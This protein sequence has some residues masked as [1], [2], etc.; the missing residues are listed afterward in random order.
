[1]PIARCLLADRMATVEP[2]TKVESGIPVAA[3]AKRKS[4]FTVARKTPNELLI[5]D[6]KNWRISCGVFKVQ[7]EYEVIVEKAKENKRTIDAEM[8]AQGYKDYNAFAR[9]CD[10]F[11]LTCSASELAELGSG[12]VLYFHFLSFIMI[13]L[14]CFIVVSIPALTYYKDQNNIDEWFWHEWSSGWS[15]TDTSCECLGSNDGVTGPSDQFS[16]SDY[17][18]SCMAWDINWCLAADSPY[19][20]PGQWCCRSWCFAK[21][22][23]VAPNGDSPSMWHRHYRG[24]VRATSTCAQNATLL[25]QCAH[26][27]DTAMN[28]EGV[29]WVPP[30]L[31]IN[32]A[33][34]TPGNLGPNGGDEASI[35]VAC[36]SI[37]PLMG[38]LAVAAYQHQLRT[39]ERID[40]DNTSPHD[41]AIMVKGLPPTVTDEKAILG[42]FR[43][44]AIKGQDDVEVVKVVI[45]W[46]AADFM[47]RIQEMTNLKKQLRRLAPDRADEEESIKKRIH[48]ITV[49]LATTATQQA[50]KLRSSGVAVVV[51]RYQQDMRACLSRW[52]G[53]W[54]SYWYCE[55]R[56]I[57]WLPKN[58]GLLRGDAL[59]QF[60]VGDGT[61][62]SLQVIRAPNPGD[63]NWMKLGVNKRQRQLRLARTHGL[64]LLVILG[65]FWATWGLNLL[66]ELAKDESAK[67]TG[68]VYWGVRALSL[69]PGLGIGIVNIVLQFLARYLGEGEY[70]DTHT[71]KEFSQAMKMSVGMMI[72]T[73]GVLLWANAKPREWYEKGGLVDDITWVLVMDAVV[74]QLWMFMDIVYLMNSYQ[75]RKVSPERLADWNDKIAKNNPPKTPEQ[76]TEL[77]LVREQ[78]LHA[79]R[80]FEPDSPDNPQR[81]AAAINS[82]VCCLFYMPLIPLLPFICLGGLL[83]QYWVDKFLLL[84]WQKRPRHQN[85]HMAIWSL[86]FL[87]VCAPSLWAAS[88]F[89][90]LTPS[91]NDKNANWTVLVLSMI[92]ALTASLV[93]MKFWRAILCL[94]CIQMEGDKSILED[95]SLEDYYNAQHMWSKEMKYHKDQFLYKMLKEEKNPEMLKP[96]EDATIRVEDVKGYYGAAV[97]HV[98]ETAGQ[99]PAAPVNFGGAYGY[100]MGGQDWSGW[101]GQGW[102]GYSDWSADSAGGYASP[103][104]TYGG[105]GHAAGGQAYG[106]QAYGGAAVAPAAGYGYGASGYTTSTT[107]VALDTSAPAYRLEGTVPGSTTTATYAPVGTMYGAAQYVTPATGFHSPTPAYEWPAH[108]Y[109]GKATPGYGR[110]RS[111]WEYERGKHG[112]YVPFDMA[113]QMEVEALYQGY[114]AGGGRN[115][116]NIRSRGIN[117]SVDFATMTQKTARARPHNIRRRESE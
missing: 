25:A 93:P 5:D 112:E 70:H 39:E 109:T 95:E 65:S 40:A 61:A 98:A 110:L 51:F 59:P 28:E 32:E 13:L 80:A 107:A 77:K 26:L 22:T 101:G 105:G 90:F 67:Q 2:G 44:H 73:S 52:R 81:Y 106:G 55:A 37:T 74:G 10:R 47:G 89:L 36:I 17:G 71:E 27:E 103:P 4:R 50:A 18:T 20:Q 85:S 46:D 116:V 48:K 87:K 16:Q 3:V 9:S 62:V 64:M 53:F 60:P 82:F 68:D 23:C 30:D 11:A 6:F 66:Q 15:S 83:L 111:W 49:E 1:M 57:T 97:Q 104:V 54:P 12:F 86:K 79:K 38:L 34:L 94:P 56:D 72:N 33:Y 102:S 24:L 99:A 78:V 76:Q 41:F 114:K 115:R 92:M 21:S 84:R 88:V 8:K 58:N 31:F 100:A 117:V 42:F 91:W 7:K 69:L 43:E 96:G 113:C 63:I 14:L 75:R 29:E 19:S 45:G 108:G 35:L